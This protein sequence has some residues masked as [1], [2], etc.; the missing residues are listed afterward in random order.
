M[1]IT[2][3]D[4]AAEWFKKEVGLVS[5]D[6]VKFYGQFYGKSK[7]QEVYSLGFSIEEA[8][9]PF[10]SAEVDGMKFYVEVGD[11]WFFNEHDVLV[12]YNPESDELEYEYTL[13]VAITNPNGVATAQ[14]EYLNFLKKFADAT[15]SASPKESR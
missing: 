4:R 12:D 9:D 13:D 3:S 5:G 6:Q 1:K 7:V 10:M 11:E 8:I 15:T 14:P 2:V